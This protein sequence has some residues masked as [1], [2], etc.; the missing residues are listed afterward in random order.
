MWN[1]SVCSK[2]DNNINNSLFAKKKIYFSSTRPFYLSTLFVHL[3]VLP[4]CYGN[5]WPILYCLI[6]TCIKY[7]FR[8]IYHQKQRN[9]KGEN[10]RKQ[11]KKTGRLCPGQSTSRLLQIYGRKLNGCLISC[12]ILSSSGNLP[13]IPLWY[14]DSP[15][16]INVLR[17][18][19]LLINR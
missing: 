4:G 13:P 16:Q 6:M 1:L 17:Q 9:Q 14:G 10:S 3:I 11:N 19:L 2:E 5:R 8:L 7:V 15:G 18:T 12:S